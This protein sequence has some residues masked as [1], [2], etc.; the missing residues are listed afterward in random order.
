MT[1]TLGIFVGGAA[2]RMH[3]VAKGLIAPSEGAAAPVE[4]ALGLATS[5]G[6]PCVFVGRNDLYERAFPHVLAIADD[7][8]GIGP[9]G[10]LRALCHRVG[11]GAVI[12]L[13]CDMPSVPVSVLRRLADPSSRAF[14]LLPRGNGGFWEP[15]CA[16]YD[17]ARL[18]PALDAAVAAGQ[19]SLQRFL[20]CSPVRELTLDDEERAA[21]VDWDCPADLPPGARGPRL[22]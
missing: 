8:A 9:L 19:H 12:A 6:L 15:L 18:R 4:R 14:A 16:R 20:A 1:A 22:C 2:L 17:A 10:G 21:L 13:A 11:T 3:G 7:P 5:L